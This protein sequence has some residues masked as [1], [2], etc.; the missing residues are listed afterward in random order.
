[1]RPRLAFTL[2]ELVATMLSATILIVGLAGAVSVS[3]QLFD[4]EALDPLNPTLPELNASE[5]NDRMAADLRYAT[6]VQDNNGSS[7]ILTRTAPESQ[8]LEQVT[9]TADANGLSR[10][11]N[12]GPVVVLQPAQPTVSQSIDSY[13]IPTPSPT[14]TVHC[15][16]ISKLASANATTSLNLPMPAGCV[17]GDLVLLCVSG[18]F[19][20]SAVNLSPSGW[21][22]VRDTSQSSMR[23]VVYFRSYTA[24]SPGPI[25]ITITSSA[26]LAA[27]A[28]G[29]SDAHPWNPIAFSDTR[30]GY[31]IPLLTATH[32]SALQPSV[33]NPS[34]G[35]IQFVSAE[36]DQWEYH[37]FG[38][39][40]YVDVAHLLASPSS[41]SVALGAAFRHGRDE[42]VS[43]PRAY[44]SKFGRWL[45]TAVGIEVAP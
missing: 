34:R 16:G 22:T 41:Q 1:M 35:M 28:I 14:K 40:T 23:Q 38:M 32:P 37:T 25:E 5:L 21:N 13:S 2:I 3:A 11:V 24:A 8:V 7:W 44:C 9:Y 12:S 39:S 10:Q 26:A 27:V 6:S 45:Q 30:T 42:S 33:N 17:P 29:F 19:A 43:T 18:K 36:N 20:S 4:V 31:A 15:R